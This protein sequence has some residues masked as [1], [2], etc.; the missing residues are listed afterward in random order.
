MIAPLPDAAAARSLARLRPAVAEDAHR[1]LEHGDAVGFLARLDLWFA[2]VHVPVSSLYGEQCDG[3][4]GQLLQVALAATVARP[5]DLRDVDRRREVDPRW[6]Q[7]QRMVGYVAYTDRFAGTLEK[8]SG[9]LDHL[10]ELGV[11]YLHL[12][13]LLKPREAVGVGDVADHPLV[14]VPARVDLAAP[15]DVA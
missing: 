15:V 13:P 2:D 9:R 7:H 14:L 5:A 1:L 11:T 4:V 10:A 12:M 3:L 6:Y 8:L